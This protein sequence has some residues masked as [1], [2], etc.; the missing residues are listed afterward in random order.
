MKH[1]RTAVLMVGLLLAPPAADAQQ[2]GDAAL[3]TTLK[4]QADAWDVAIVRKDRRAI[5]ANMSDSF[6]QIDSDGNAADKAKFLTEI[7]ADDL[8][9]QPYT[10]E[11]F[12]IRFYGDAAII[13]GR[14][15][16]RGTYEGEPFAS[17]YRFTDVYVKESGGWRVVNIQTTRIK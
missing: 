9:I 14:T 13:N 4:A 8:T 17:H 6:V 16:M 5:A 12:K 2:S 10:V 15:L 11:D 1:W 7:T 3:A